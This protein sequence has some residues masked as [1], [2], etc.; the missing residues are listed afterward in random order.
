MLKNNNAG[1]DENIDNVC[2]VGAAVAQQQND[3]EWGASF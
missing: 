2:E 1:D 3:D